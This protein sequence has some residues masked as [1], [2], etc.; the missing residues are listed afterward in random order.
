M[1]VLLNF[2]LSIRPQRF[3]LL[4]ASC[5]GLLFLVITPPFQ[6]P[7]EINHFYR[8]YQ[9]SEGHLMAVK[10][11]HRL[12]GDV[13]LSLE[14]I[15]K[16]FEG[17]RWA[18]GVKTSRNI[19][20]ENLKQP[21]EPEVKVF[22]DFPNTALYSPVCYTPQ[23]L[24]MSVI[25]LF[26][27]SALWIFYGARFFTLLCWILAVY[28]AI[29]LTP[30]CQWL[31]TFLALLPMSVFVN[32]SL[33]ADVMTNL[34]SFLFIAITLRYA[35]DGGL[36]TRKRLVILC[37]MTFLLVSAKLIYFPIV[38]LVLII[39]SP[40]FS[41]LRHR[42]ITLSLIAVVTIGTA[43]L[44]NSMVN[45]LYTP[46]AEYN[47]DHVD[48]SMMSMGNMKEQKAYIFSHGGYIFTVV[49]KTLSAA[50]NMY[51]KGYI[52]TFGWL[53]TELPLWL[54]RSMYLLLF[55]VAIAGGEAG[56]RIKPFA[57]LVIALA[58]VLSFFMLILSQHLTWD[59]VGS[60]V[61][62]NIQGRYLIP[63]APLFFL[64]LYNKRLSAKKVVIPVVMIASLFALIYSSYTMHAR[65]FGL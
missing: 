7:D 3:F 2:F 9:L 51:Y 52:G 10:Q 31:L 39:P 50:F 64:L 18:A 63:F 15:V 16:P 41:S 40:K 29:R 54:I 38:A 33:S 42:L 19:I 1:K 26:G 17:L 36:F 49:K 48:F 62:M 6:V 56:I 4:T 12:G 27:G 55:F 53:D 44:W 32:M 35:Y 23:A 21:L 5:F 37:V 34:L 61:V 25:R 45:T 47:K 11:D 13:P 22:K 24:A 57:R 8:A 14:K 30:V 43:A 60:G 46:Y 20:T 59:M 58:F 65:Y 28:T